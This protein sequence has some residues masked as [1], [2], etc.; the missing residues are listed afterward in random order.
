M[1]QMDYHVLTW[2]NSNKTISQPWSNYL[3]K[4]FTRCIINTFAYQHK[5]IDGP[6]N[7][8][9]AVTTTDQQ[10]KERKLDPAISTEQSMIYE[11]DYH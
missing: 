10:H 8:K 2:K 3:V 9:Q 7:S 5:I 6:N 1:A 11:R 4:C